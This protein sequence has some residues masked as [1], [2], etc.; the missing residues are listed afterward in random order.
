MKRGIVWTLLVL[1]LAGCGAE[2]K[3]GISR[4]LA[5]DNVQVQASQGQVE[6]RW[7]AVANATGYN[8][9][10][11]TESIG[12][13]DNF[14]SI[15]SGEL[16]LDVTSPHTVTGLE[17]GT[18]YYFQV[19]ALNDQAE[20]AGSDEVTAV[21]IPPPSVPLGGLNDTGI[22]WCATEAEALL[23]CDDDDVEDFPVQDGMLGRDAQ[24]R[25]DPA[26]VKVGSGAA[27]FDYTRVCNS[28]ELAGQGDCPENPV[29]GH[30]PDE[31]ACTRDNVTGLIWEVK[32]DDAAHLR[33]RAHSYSWYNPDP[34]TNG[35]GAGVQNGGSCTGSA[36]DTLAYAAAVNA[37]NDGEG[38][39]GIN[40]WRLPDR[41]E[42]HSIVHY[43]ST[44]GVWLDTTHFPN[45]ASSAYWSST[46]SS[47]RADLAWAIVASTAAVNLYSKDVHSSAVRLVGGIEPMAGGETVCGTTE[48]EHITASTPTQDFVQHDDGTVTHIPTGLMWKRCREG[49]TWDAA[50]SS[51]VGD[52]TGFGWQQALQRAQA[53][54]AQNGGEGFAGHNDWRMPNLKELAS[55][56]EQR[57]AAPAT[58]V[59]IFPEDLGRATWSSSPTFSS[60]R[61]GWWRANF[62]N[63]NVSISSTD[64]EPLLRLRLVRVA[65]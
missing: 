17:N 37:L 8:L 24:A 59:A 55:I 14:G 50:A 16:V 41:R 56:L 60:S 12:D 21:P 4:L 44:S 45:T 54:N 31:W 29:L 11:A 1:G 33:H 34:D 20:S 47:P 35:G 46:P 63:S 43:G 65:E 27:G 23:P 39:C 52:A 18:T 36:C 57:C 10:Y 3:V 30:G 5:P 61:L 58:N 7:D 42:L 28:G 32:V 49:E 62:S 64:E 51:C 22:D 9:Y 13:I 26:F 40:D 25:D 15:A 48:N 53:V 6:V 2:S 38:L 19:T